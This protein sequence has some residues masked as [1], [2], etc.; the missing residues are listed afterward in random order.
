MSTSVER[1]LI[2]EYWYRILINLSLEIKDICSI[3]NEFG[4]EYEIFD[5]SLIHQKLDISDEGMTVSKAV[6]PNSRPKCS[7]F[8]SIIANPGRKYHWKF[9]VLKAT[10]AQ[11]M[12]FVNIGVIEDG[13]AVQGALDHYWWTESYG[14]SFFS[15]GSVWNNHKSFTPDGYTDK[16]EFEDEIHV[17][18]DL[19]TDG[20]YHIKFGRNEEVFGK[21]FDMKQNTNYRMAVSICEG[22]VKLLSFEA[23]S[24]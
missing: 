19:K 15:S 23:C 12:L 13:E 24:K 18:L 20:D 10:P 11:N 2:I 17:W 14:Y 3:I 16:M 8:G 22:K 6:D 4:D 7:A 21:A 5:P 9:Q 1:E